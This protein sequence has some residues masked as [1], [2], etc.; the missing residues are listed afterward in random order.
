MKR[1]IK[2]ITFM[3]CVIMLCGSVLPVSQ[4]KTTQAAVRLNRYSVELV[5][6]KTFQLK[7]KS[8]SKKR[9]FSEEEDF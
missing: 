5:E 8:N 6:G 2:C 1:F 9:V 3:L 4:I 7:L